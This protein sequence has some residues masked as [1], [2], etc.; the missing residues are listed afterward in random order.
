M[1]D[2]A[3]D[4]QFP[5]TVYAGTLPGTVFRSL[6]RGGSWTEVASSIADTVLALAINPLNSGVIYAGTLRT[7]VFK[8]TDRAATWDSVNVGLPDRQVNVLLIDPVD[9]NQVWAG[10]SD[11][12][13]V[14]TDGGTSWSSAG[15]D[16]TRSVNVTSLALNPL[17]RDRI[18]AGT[19]ANGVYR[20]TDG[21]VSWAQVN[22][23]LG[24]LQIA[25]LAIHP[26]RPDT[27]YAASFISG[28]FRSSD[29][30]DSWAAANDS[31]T[32]L[33]LSSI[34]ISPN[35]PNVLYLGTDSPSKVFKSADNGETWS[36]LTVN[37]PSE[38]AVDAIVVHPDSVGV[39][40]A[41]MSTVQRIRQTGLDEKVVL[42]TSEQ[43]VAV[44]AAD[45]DGDGGLDPVVANG[46]DGTLS[47]YMNQDQGISFIRKTFVVGGEPVSVSTG[48]LDQDGDVD[49]VVGNRISRVV[50]VV[51]NTGAGVMAFGSDLFVGEEPTATALADI[52]G[53]GRIDILTSNAEPGN[54]VSFFVNNSQGTFFSQQRF[55]C[56]VDPAALAVA[57]VNGDGLLDVL[58]ANR[59]DGTISVLQNVGGA[60]FAAPQAVSVG[61]SPVGVVA[62]DFDLDGDLDVAALADGTWEIV[63]LKNGGDGTF[64]VS[65]RQALDAPPIAI[66]SADMD[67][68]LY[69]DLVISG[70][71]RPVSLVANNG[72]GGFDLPL[73]TLDELQTAGNL[74]VADLNADGSPDL[75]AVRADTRALHIRRND[76]PVNIKPPAPPRAPAA[77]DV[78]ADLGGR[79]RITWQLP[80][81]DEASGRVT[82]YQIFR[83]QILEGPFSLRISVDT[84]RT[85]VQPDSLSLKG[86]FIDS[87]AMVDV[88]YFYYVVAT[89]ANQAVST[90]SDTVSTR[91]L[92]QPFF[93]FDFSGNGDY[94]IGDSLE[95]SISLIPLDQT[96]S[97]VS[98]YL[99]YDATALSV[100]D[101]D[102]AR[103]GV[104]AIDPGVQKN[105]VLENR[106]HNDLAGGINYSLGSP[107]N[108]SL[109]SFMGTAA[110]TGRIALGTVRFMALKDTV[111]HISVV[112]SPSVNRQ[113]AVIEQGTG[114][115][116]LPYL[117]PGSYV[118]DISGVRIFGR[119]HFQGRN[120]SSTAMLRV[121]LRSSNGSVVPDSVY[122][123]PNDLDQNP[124]NGVQIVPDS[125]GG[126]S[127]SQ[128]PQ[129]TYAI[130]VKSFH[131][132]RG[133]ALG[134]SIAVGTSSPPELSFYWRSS[135]DSAATDTLRGGDANDDDRIN[136]ADFGILASHFGDAGVD[137]D[138][139]A[140]RADFNGDRVISIADF[141]LLAS[142]FG[143]SGLGTA[144]IFKPAVGPDIFALLPLGEGA[145]S[146]VLTAPFRA[147]GFSA[148][149]RPPP[150]VD[151]IQ[152]LP[153]ASVSADN[154]Q[155]LWIKRVVAPDRIRIAAHLRPGAPVIPAGSEVARIRTGGPAPLL[156]DLRV[157]D[158]EGR[159]Y[160]AGLGGREVET[161]APDHPALYQNAP[162]PF[163]PSTA[164]RFDVSEAS[165]VT[166][167]IYNLLG[168]EVRRLIRERRRPGS[169]TVIWDGTDNTDRR[170]ASGIY[171]YQ[172][173]IG[174]FRD[175]KKLVL[176]R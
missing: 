42:E 117:V 32:V 87:T 153:G 59:G 49:L 107:N 127:L 82:G 14:T 27:L 50:G 10:T 2:I 142:N 98:L 28:V 144:V 18:Y 163:N 89:G 47:L 75:L 39:V 93:V 132:L 1:K 7:G 84:S 136:L 134:D 108:V 69:A 17:D 145:Y 22:S 16:S 81:A 80:R 148:E 171:L 34:A 129:G 3:I 155:A 57:D 118:V 41:G 19:I 94:H 92:A 123:P 147:A 43:P 140:W 33:T 174:R 97:G 101:A 126:F 161:G 85:S 105:N 113:T 133:Q 36:D 154:P 31:L 131:Y 120:G 9:T 64:A 168:Q 99:N 172:V 83:S 53:D 143:E 152:V 151:Q 90:S 111:T 104:Q 38:L 45:L 149:V 100:V 62:G 11:S 128:V 162:N 44:G 164:I 160:A 109:G 110:D 25:A 175:V 26:T 125:T 29:G 130:Y 77:E 15:L 169:Y 86:I 23:G 159:L 54:S 167:S 13:F 121:D 70:E 119:V 146:L 156:E 170:V 4:P 96:V 165:D 48:D 40:Y 150:G 37:L 157:I 8:T 102:P 21:R 173:S 56:G 124:A 51:L 65:E 137:E 95:V 115:V 72:Q 88:E 91:S 114:G 135:A 73:L 46:A 103:S 20:S 67:G 35:S 106:L 176:L 138:E 122:R 116:V 63:V 55:S 58:T 79:I 61:G 71:G 12:L 30:G 68:D 141:G 112:D 5:D 139:P 74:D 24:S 60:V 6:D 78:Q 52:D 76:L 158:P 66:E 166:L